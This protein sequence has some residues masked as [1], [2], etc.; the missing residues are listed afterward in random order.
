VATPVDRPAATTAGCRARV[1]R[2]WRTAPAGLAVGDHAGLR[3]LYPARDH[4]EIAARTAALVESLSNKR[5]SSWKELFS[6][7]YKGHTL[8]VWV[9][10]TSSYF[11][12]NGINNW[13]P[14]LYKT[15]YHLPLQESLRR[16]SI[17]NVLSMRAIGTVFLMFALA[18]A[19]GLIAATRMIE[20]NDR[21]LKDISP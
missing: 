9:L 20:I 2:R 5:K 14:T 4:A 3:S 6:P 13:L 12:A 18:N 17:S 11:V 8:V 1:P 16:A 10:W 19:V 7:I 15:V 21:T